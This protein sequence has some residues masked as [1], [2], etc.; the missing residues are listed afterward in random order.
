MPMETRRNSV[1][2][3]CNVDTLCKDKCKN[4]C[5]CKNKG[6]LKKMKDG[7]KVDW[8]KK[9]KDFDTENQLEEQD[10]E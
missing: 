6:R 3:V 1:T 9:E 10:E 7:R 4:K 8:R 5:K 2:C